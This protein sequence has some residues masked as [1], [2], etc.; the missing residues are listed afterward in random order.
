MSF[1]QSVEKR[2][3]PK[4]TTNNDPIRL[5]VTRKSRK[6]QRLWS[7]DLMALYKYAYYYYYYYKTRHTFQKPLLCAIYK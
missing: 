4:K 1:K 3:P 6:L 2:E 7:Y 5:T